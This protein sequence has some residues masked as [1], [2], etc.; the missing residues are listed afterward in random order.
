MNVGL[1]VDEAI[2]SE[3]TACSD[4]EFHEH[5]RRVAASS[6]SGKLAH[7]LSGTLLFLRYLAAQE[8]LEANARAAAREEVA[9][10]EGLLRGFRAARLRFNEA[11][12]VVLARVVLR[13][14]SRVAA[15]RDLQLRTTVDV[16]PDLT[17]L[18]DELALELLLVPLLRRVAVATPAGGEV[19]VSAAS[20]G[21][22][23]S[24]PGECSVE[25][26]IES[27]AGEGFGDIG[28]DN[29]LAVAGYYRWSVAPIESGKQTAFRI[30]IP[31]PKR[32]LQ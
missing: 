31:A 20:A 32:E 16:Q 14:L 5:E 7:E 27:E 23:H 12:E 2:G 4:D 24:A 3:R 25:L 8:R 17:V 13:A 1:Q 19:R 6:L 9:R 11:A 30:S 26:R 29:A 22:L 15:I 28:I 18:C 21:A 10:L